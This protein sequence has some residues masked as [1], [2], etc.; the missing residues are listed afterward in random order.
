MP[1]QLHKQLLIPS[2]RNF[3]KP[4]SKLINSRRPMKS[5]RLHKKIRKLQKPPERRKESNR[6]LMLSLMLRLT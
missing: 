2:R 1:R 3:N 4:K 6:L 5:S